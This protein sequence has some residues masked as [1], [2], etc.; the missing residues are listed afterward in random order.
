M[1][2]PNEQRPDNWKTEIFLIREAAAVDASAIAALLKDA[3]A[4]FEALYTAEAFAATVVPESMVRERIKVGPVWIATKESAAVGTVAALCEVDS[5]MVRGM[6]VA[7]GA[8]GFGLAQALLGVTENFARKQG[9][10]RLSLY[11]TPFL[12]QAIHLY[13]KSGFR[14][15]GDTHNP[16]GTELL[17]MV[18]ELPAKT[19]T[20]KL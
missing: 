13:E 1:N 19:G 2:R 4:E 6:A 8:R 15:T 9:Y 10:Q 11:T 7:P 5:V 3:F 20:P 18:K 12:R 14:F 16:H 17:R